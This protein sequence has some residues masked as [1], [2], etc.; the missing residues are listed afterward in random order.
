MKR[1]VIL[2]G[3]TG[4]TMMANMLAKKLSPHEAEITLVSNSPRHQ[5]QPGWLYVPFGWQ[6]A[7]SLHRPLKGL[8]RKNVRL[9]IDEVTSL[10]HVSKTLKLA[11]GKALPYD[12]LIIS[13][14]SHVHP[15]LVPGLSEG[16]EHFYTEAAA[17]R[18]HEKLEDFQGGTILVGVGGLPYKCPVAPLEFTF[19]LDD[20]LRRR[21]IRQKTTLRYTFPINACFTIPTVATLAERMLNE[22][23]IEIETFFNLEEIDLEKKI[24][25][26]LE[27]SSFPFDLAVFVP[28]H[29]GAEFLWGHPIADQDGW[30]DVSRTTLQSKVAPDIW[31]I[32]DTTNLPISKAGSTAHFEG[33]VVA[34]HVVAAVRGK[35]VEPGHAEYDGHVMCFLE[36][37]EDKASLLDF[38]YSGPPHPKEPTTLVHYEKLL[39]NQAYW[40]LVPTALV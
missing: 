31:A 33:P 8:L 2:G 30:V 1:I 35:A 17:L 37:G 26:S 10:D 13:T 14:G 39:F 27:G 4:G 24:A 5:Y 19:L 9:R 23:G 18:L 20:Y 28:P 36:A 16:G 6:E 11:S 29:R 21:G 12:Y 3:G 22:K 15:E 34:A 40:H 38:N 32:G 25:T 7:T